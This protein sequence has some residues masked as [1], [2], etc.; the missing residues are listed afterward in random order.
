MERHIWTRH[1]YAAYT[2][3]SLNLPISLAPLCFHEQVDKL[4]NPLTLLVGPCLVSYHS[5]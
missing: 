3:G 1:P 2:C 4:I 5:H